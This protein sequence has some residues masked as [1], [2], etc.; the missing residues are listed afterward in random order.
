[1]TEIDVIYGTQSGRFLLKKSDPNHLRGIN[2]GSRFIRTEKSL[3]A[4]IFV[5]PEMM[6]LRLIGAEDHFQRY[7]WIIIV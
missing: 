7:R 3:I 1:M 2:R 4:D 6:T 5:S